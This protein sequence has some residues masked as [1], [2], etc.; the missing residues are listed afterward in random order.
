V[1][2]QLHLTWV[3]A[4]VIAAVL[5]GAGTLV[6][7]RLR[8]GEA[9][10]AV[11]ELGVVIGLFA[12]W[13]FVGSLTGHH[14]AG[15][16]ARG[17]AIWHAEQTLHIADEGSLQRPLL[18][19]HAVLAAANYY[20]AYAHWFS[21]DVVLV[22]L[23]LRHRAEYA[24]VRAG[25]VLFTGACL[26]LHMVSTAPPRLLPQTHLVDTAA[27]LGQSAVDPRRLGSAVRRRGVAHAIAPRP[28]AHL[29]ARGAHV[30]RHRRHRQ[31]LLA[32]CCRRGRGCRDRLAGRVRSLPLPVGVASRVA[33]CLTWRGS[34]HGSRRGSNWP[35]RSG[36]SGSTTG[37]TRTS[38][39]RAAR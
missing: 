17:A 35:K 23:W 25:L 27:A 24:V 30:V 7:A 21:V 26:F 11:R 34:L 37:C 10:A 20:Y 14:P 1:V 5:I 39:P 29:G 15:A 16:Y 9:G 36:S 3:T 22:W 2:P 28:R 18:D 31:P 19:H 12:L 4:G 38:R 33:D 13:H 8:R 32:R 6:A